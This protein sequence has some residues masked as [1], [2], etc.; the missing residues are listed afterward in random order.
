[1]QFNMFDPT[2]MDLKKEMINYKTKLQLK[3]LKS[4]PQKPRLENYEPKVL[5]LPKTNNINGKEFKSTEF[6]FSKQLKSE[7]KIKVDKKSNTIYKARATLK[8]RIYSTSN[9]F[10]YKKISIY[11]SA[12]IDSSFPT[13]SYFYPK[14]A[15]FYGRSQSSSLCAILNRK[16]ND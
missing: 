4:S 9:T 8:T 15:S 16:K 12:E 6:I 11:N 14:F 5:I 13:A 3:Q 10:H 1:M 2:K 7:D